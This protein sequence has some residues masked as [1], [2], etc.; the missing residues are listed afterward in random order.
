[1]DFS[2]GLSSWRQAVRHRAKVKM[3]RVCIRWS[4]VLSRHGLLKG[5]RWTINS[6]VV[7][8]PPGAGASSFLEVREMILIQHGPNEAWRLLRERISF[9][10]RQHFGLPLQ[11]PHAKIDEPGIAADVAEGGKPH[12]PI[13]ARLVRS[14]KIR[15][16]LNVS[17][18]V[19]E[20]ISLP[21]LAVVAAF[22]NDFGSSHGHDGKQS[23]TIDAAK[24]SPPPIQGNREG[25][26]VWTK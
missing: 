5:N 26:P 20:L 10:Q 16:T 11:E 24:G 19:L 3:A 6:L 14:N 1:M 9:Q 12:L 18:L 7:A 21:A 22:H 13:Q 4:G 2:D 25:I 17:R 15:R 23:I 8:T